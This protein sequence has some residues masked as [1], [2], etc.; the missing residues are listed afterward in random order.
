[1]FWWWESNPPFYFKL[2]EIKK[3]IFNRFL[4]EAVWKPHN[5]QPDIMT[6]HLHSLGSS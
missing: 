3:E 2:I 1:M 4:P 6:W 5:P